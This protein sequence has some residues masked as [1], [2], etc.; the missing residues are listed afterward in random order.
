M[1]KKIHDLE[2]LKKRNLKDANHFHANGDTRME[3]ICIARA[4]AYQNAISI[5]NGVSDKELEVLGKV[6]QIVSLEQKPTSCEHTKL[7]AFEMIES[8]IA[9]YQ[10]N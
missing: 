10:L 4:D 2:T 1:N 7:K 8:V 3:E 5:I 6:I 9:D